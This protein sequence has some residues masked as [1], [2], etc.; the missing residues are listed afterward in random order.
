MLYCATYPQ[1]EGI[2]IKGTMSKFFITLVSIVLL[3][4]SL[5]A[6]NVAADCAY[7]QSCPP[8][9]N[10][11]INKMVENPI[12]NVYVEN[13]GSSDATFSPGSN[14]TFHLIITNSSGETFNPVE[15][16][17]QFP[18]YLT[19][20]SSSVQ[21]T[22]DAGNH[23]LV[24]T[25]NNLIAGETRTLEVV[26][27]VADKAQL[28]TDKNP[29]CTDNYSKVTAP[30]RPDGDDDRAGFCISTSVGGAQNLP[31]AGFNDLA[32][33]IPFLSLGGIGLVLLRKK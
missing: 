2:F 17:D 15:V 23:R 24:M 7:G 9:V 29:L 6:T 5:F 25:L 27:K 22:Y 21:G 13:L 14:V 33:V 11:T 28:P 8:P 4:S 16:V 10:L 30:A 32:T 12:T 3:S 26:A 18:N 31:V 19:Y 1:L 20:V